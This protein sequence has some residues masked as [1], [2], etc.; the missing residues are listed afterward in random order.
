VRARVRAAARPPAALLDLAARWVERFA[1]VLDVRSKSERGEL[2]A[3]AKTVG[4]PVGSGRIR[5]SAEASAAQAVQAMLAG[6]LSQTLANAAP[7]AEAVHEPEHLHQLRVGLRRLRNVLRVFGPVLAAPAPTDQAGDTV[8]HSGPVDDAGPADSATASER[9]PGRRPAT[10]GPTVAL[11]SRLGAT[12]D[13][14]VAAESIWPALR[15][16]GAPCV[17]WPEEAA[18]DVPAL[19]CEPATAAAVAGHARPRLA[20]HRDH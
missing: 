12:R 16:A 18:S 15:D 3:A 10:A 19:L 20:R 7:I 6:A 1:L 13:R 11:Y 4:A 5:L 14:D 8:E 17:E 9:E 2:L